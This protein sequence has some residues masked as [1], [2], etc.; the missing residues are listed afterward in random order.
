[1]RVQQG[2]EEVFLQLF[3]LHIFSEPDETTR[4]DVIPE[5]ELRESASLKQPGR[6]CGDTENVKN[7]TEDVEKQ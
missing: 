5:I 4:R 7:E 1:M 3:I 6:M 2:A